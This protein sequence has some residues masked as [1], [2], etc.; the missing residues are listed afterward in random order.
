MA[1]FSL[2]K[3]AFSVLSAFSAFLAFSVKR[4]RD[5]GKICVKGKVGEYVLICR[6]Q[7][8]VILAQQAKPNLTN[9][10]SACQHVS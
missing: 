6:P 3:K 7:R 9:T 4:V 8:R 10:G 2:L 5:D 1:I